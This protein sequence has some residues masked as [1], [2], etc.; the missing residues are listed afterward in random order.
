[1][2]TPFEASEIAR[3]EAISNAFSTFEGFEH[4]LTHYAYESIE[5]SFTGD[6]CLELGPA[7]G[8][9]TA[10]LLKRFPRLTAV[11]GSSAYCEQLRERHAGREGFEVVC[12]LFEHFG[13]D[14]TW[15]TVLAAHVVEHV[16]DPV[17]LLVNAHDWIATGGRLIVQVPNARSFH[18]LLGV[19][20]DTIHDVYELSERDHAIGHR[21][22]Y[23]ADALRADI[24]KAGWSVDEIVGSYFKIF[25]NA[26]SEAWFDDGLIRAFYELGKDFPEQGTMIA[27]VCTLPD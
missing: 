12:S 7:D 19:K 22:V 3:L 20:L 10:E 1:M 21:R 14:Q 27:A 2:G 11:D 26:Q 4:H 17:A 15:D 18:R 6:S 24:T 13:S 23:D 16:E 5:P 8:H 25:S 9:M